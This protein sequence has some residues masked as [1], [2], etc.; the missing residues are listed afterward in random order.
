M[1]MTE[2]SAAAQ[3]GDF[4]VIVNNLLGI[5]TQ[6]VAIFNNILKDKDQ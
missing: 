1:V 4:W 3:E 6:C 5:S 2:L